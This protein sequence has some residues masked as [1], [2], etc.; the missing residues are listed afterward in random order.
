MRHDEG[1]SIE[2]YGDS[3]LMLLGAQQNLKEHLSSPDLICRARL[4][5]IMRRKIGWG[6]SVLRGT[7][8]EHRRHLTNACIVSKWQHCSAVTLSIL[9]PL[10]LQPL[11]FWLLPKTARINGIQYRTPLVLFELSTSVCFPFLFLKSNLAGQA[12]QFTFVVSVL[13]DIVSESARKVSCVFRDL[14]GSHC[15]RRRELAC[16]HNTVA[17]ND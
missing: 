1:M 4:R 10:Q 15:G 2:R 16:C 8:I 12:G 11:Q 3:A 5:F 9:K 6:G 17:L 14:E 13:T 7:F